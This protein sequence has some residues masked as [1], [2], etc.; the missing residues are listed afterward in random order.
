MRGFKVTEKALADLKEIARYTQNRWG[1]DQRIKYLAQLDS[2][3]ARLVNDPH[4][5][6]DYSE[7]RSG[8]RGYI[9]GKHIVFFRQKNTHIEIIRILHQSMD[10]AVRLN[11]N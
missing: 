6:T 5:G 11:A 3:F 8:Y 4:L 9:E 7:V 10:I 2:L 1:R